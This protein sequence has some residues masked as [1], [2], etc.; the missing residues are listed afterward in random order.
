MFKLL[1]AFADAERP[2][3]F[4]AEP[5]TQRSGV[6]GVNAAAYSARRLAACA[7]RALL[8]AQPLQAGVPG[9][10]GARVDPPFSRD[11]LSGSLPVAPAAPRSAR[12]TS[13]PRS[14]SA[15]R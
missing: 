8:T 9:E 4:G 3:G 15:C 2:L 10:R 12:M 1:H 11:R 13:H 14:P 7:A 5:R 6:S